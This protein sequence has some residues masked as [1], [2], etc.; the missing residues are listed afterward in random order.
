M[1][2]RFHE[3]EHAL[4]DAAARRRRDFDEV[5]PAAMAIEYF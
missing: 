2:S 4:K 3:G 5:S 1:L